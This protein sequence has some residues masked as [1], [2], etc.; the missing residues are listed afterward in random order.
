M[1][2]QI[3]SSWTSEEKKDTPVSQ[4][5]ISFVSP[6]KQISE[7]LI[8]PFEEAKKKFQNTPPQTPTIQRTEEI[9]PQYQAK[10]PPQIEQK[11]LP[12]II[13]Q[14]NQI[15][16]PV[17]TKIKPPDQAKKNPFWKTSLKT[18]ALFAG[19]AFFVYMFLNWQAYYVKAQYILEHWGGKN[20]ASKDILSKPIEALKKVAPPTTSGEILLPFLSQAM[21]TPIK[22][23]SEATQNEIKQSSSSGNINISDLKDNT[24]IIPKINIKASI[25]WNSAPDE[26]VMLENLQ[27]GVVHY[28]GTALPG[29]G[30]GPIFITGHSSYYWW[31]KGNYKTVFANLDKIETGDE[32]GIGYNNKVYLYKVYEKIVVKPEQVDVLQPVDQPILALMTCVPVGTNLNRLIVRAKEIDTSETVTNTTTSSA[33]TNSGSTGN[34]SSNSTN[35]TNKTSAPL[36]TIFLLPWYWF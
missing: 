24:M 2:N 19:I 26:N 27:K 12:P 14:T 22:N 32:I 15:P 30:K 13:P 31:D 8:D 10:I 29:T 33:T 17:P 5:E 1:A 7:T 21:E 3:D 18:L 11:N 16:Q 25:I 9:K 23:L 6:K 4:P 36:D 35:Q 28:A 34:N 20:E